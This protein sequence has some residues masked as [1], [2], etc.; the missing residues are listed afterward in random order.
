MS[1]FIQ[2]KHFYAEFAIKKLIV[3]V[4]FAFPL[5]STTDFITVLCNRSSVFLDCSSFVNSSLFT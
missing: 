2:T 1:S 5:Y 3:S 4:Q